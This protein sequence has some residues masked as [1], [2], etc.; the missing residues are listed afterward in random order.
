M[1]TKPSRPNGKTR[2]RIEQLYRQHPDW[3]LERFARKLG[4][5][6]TAVFYHLVDVKAKVAASQPSKRSR[7]Y[8]ARRLMVADPYGQ[9]EGLQ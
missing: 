8:R 1:K 3:T 2:Q 9:I 6:T 4:M 5:S 7:P